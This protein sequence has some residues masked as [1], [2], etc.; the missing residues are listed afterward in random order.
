MQI[1]KNK[2]APCFLTLIVLAASVLLGPM[3]GLYAAEPSSILDKIPAD[4]DLTD[5]DGGSFESYSDLDGLGRCGVAYANIG[6][7]LMPT[8]DRGTISEVKPTGWVQNQYDFVSGKSLYNRCHLIGFQLTGENANE[9]NLITGTR[10]V[11]T[12]GMLPG[13]TYCTASPRFLKRIT[14]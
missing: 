4:L 14:W 3:Q 5:A 6:E 2:I 11:N 7:D 10:Y 8:E 9:E 12:E 1:V 13:T